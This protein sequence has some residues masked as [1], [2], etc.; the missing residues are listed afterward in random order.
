MAIL[1]DYVCPT[2]AG[3][4]EARVAIPPPTSRDCP[5]CG[6][7]ARRAWAPVGL[8]RGG[9]SAP[10]GPRAATAEPS[11]CTR[12]PDVLGLC[13][14]TPDAGRAWVARVR[15]D[16]RTLE[17]ELAKQEAAAAVRTPKL[18]DVL[19]HSHARPAPAG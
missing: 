17:R 2:C 6:S 8:S 16:N 18:D 3:R 9:A 1:V 13:H 5:A 14:M 7:T 19:S 15:G 10:A 12:N 4:F 11:L